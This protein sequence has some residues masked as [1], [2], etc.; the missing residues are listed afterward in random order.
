M[1]GTV[2]YWAPH[3][4]NCGYEYARITPVPV[5]FHQTRNGDKLYKVNLM[6]SATAVESAISGEMQVT[7]RAHK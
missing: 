3:S 2:H 4:Y 7:D 5:A 1:R 6:S